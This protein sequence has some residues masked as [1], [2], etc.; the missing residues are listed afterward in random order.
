MKIS[1]NIVLSNFK[2]KLSKEKIK[3]N[4]NFLLKNKNEILKS[5]SPSY[6]YK[7]SNKFLKK[8]KKK[9]LNLR[10][11]GM[12]GSILGLKAISQFL[13]SK[14]KKKV[15][16]IDNLNPDLKNYKDL[17]KPLNLVISKSGNTLE[18]I[19]NV[20][21]LVKKNHQN[22]FITQNSES[23]L[24][25]L[26][27][28]LKAHVIDHNNFIGGRYSVLSEVG[29]LPSILLGLKEKKFKQLNNIVKNKN[30]LDSLI[31]NTANIIFFLKKKKYNSVILNYDKDSEDL[32]KW[33]QQLVGESL[34]KKQKGAFPIISTMPKDNHSLMQLY[35]DGPKNN[36]F[37]FFSV[38]EK[39]S[40]KI[41]NS[42]LLKSHSYLK[43]KSFGLILNS[44][45][46]ASEKVFFKKKIPFRSFEIL[47]RNEETLGEL[48]TFFIL[49]TILV[50]KSLGLN[51]Y[52]QPAVELIKTE[53]KK[54]LIS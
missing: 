13:S 23:Y 8:I 20:N 26:A 35:L 14:I 25:V 52:N 4:L 10:V 19:A 22:I 38:N 54:R 43:N 2:K 33:Y 32:F 11:I 50:S 18:T 46:L 53:T 47:R 24:K 42:K 34:G 15:I 40:E 3:K 44:Q 12:G 49:E 1:N 27:N 6:K 30:F 41:I 28:K 48:F 31:T 7:Y 29:M 45:K 5:C 9:S 39:K 21:I 36:F 16:Y 17:K 37:T 51:P